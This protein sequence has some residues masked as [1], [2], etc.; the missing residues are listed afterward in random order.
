MKVKNTA[1]SPSMA[2]DYGLRVYG[3]NQLLDTVRGTLEEKTFDIS[4]YSTV[5][6]NGNRVGYTQRGEVTFF[7]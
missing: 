6:I 1:N 4:P 7:D 5:K 3:D 2:M